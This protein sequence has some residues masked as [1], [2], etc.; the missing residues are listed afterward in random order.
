ML[1]HLICC[2][3]LRLSTLPLAGHY[4]GRENALLCLLPLDLE[5]SQRAEQLVDAPRR[6]VLARCHS[7]LVLI[8]VHC[9]VHVRADDR[10]FKLWTILAGVARV[11]WSQD[12]LLEL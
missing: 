3:L 12:S 11:N 1:E 7:S 2:L 9:R 4:V 8:T 6:L 10:L 5:S